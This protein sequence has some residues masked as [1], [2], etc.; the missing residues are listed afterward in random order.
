MRWSLYSGQGSL[1]WDKPS[2]GL[3]GKPTGFAFYEGAIERLL[4]IPRQPRAAP[5]KSRRA[6]DDALPAAPLFFRPRQ[7]TLTPGSPCTSRTV[8][9]ALWGAPDITVS[10]R[11]PGEGKDRHRT[12]LGSGG[13]PGLC[14][15]PPGPRS[16]R[17]FAYRDGPELLAAHPGL[18]LQHCTHQGLAHRTRLRRWWREW[19]NDDWVTNKWPRPRTRVRKRNPGG[20]SSPFGY[21]CFPQKSC[22][23]N[24][25]KIWRD[26]R[27]ESK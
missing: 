9:A 15:N 13:S 3:G 12:P 16:P 25:K 2:T 5:D 24:L 18:Q 17:K 1:S 10:G 8:V 11:D 19:V 4:S 27:G 26:L 7:V 20:Q 21:S 6:S 22:S 23:S 14:G